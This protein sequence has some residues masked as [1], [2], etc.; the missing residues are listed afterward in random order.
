MD[1]PTIQITVHLE[2]DLQELLI[3]ELADRGFEA[4]EQDGMTLRACTARSRWSDELEAFLTNWLERHGSGRGFRRSIIPNRNWN[5][6]WEAS[7]EPIEVGQFVITP[8]WKRRD[9]VREAVAE[10][11][12]TE[13]D[14]AGAAAASLNAAI[15]IEIDPKMSFG[16]G[17][18][19]STRLALRA[20][21]HEVR[22]GDRVL[23]AG[24]GTG[25]LAIAAAKL[26]AESVLAFDND[27]WAFQNCTENVERNG[28]ADVVG[29]RLGD[30]RQIPDETFDLVLVN[31]HL[32]VI[33]VMMSSFDGCLAPDGR[34]IVSGLLESNQPEIRTLASEFGWRVDREEREDEWYA[35]TLVRRSA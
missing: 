25:I 7:I 9:S 23:D 14:D 29:V 5:E 22:R 13:S 10:S 28:V 3:A 1:G 4:F 15:V 16:T 19:A 31:I 30:D 20:L 27:P 35:A 33:R 11:G 2:E 8:S 17:H 32:P 6:V 21:E 12:S 34:I 18:H 24:S 26:G